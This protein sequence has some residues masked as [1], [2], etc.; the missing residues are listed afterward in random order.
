MPEKEEVFEI[1]YMLATEPIQF[2]DKEELLRYVK[3]WQVILYLKDWDITIRVVDN[4]DMPGFSSTKSVLGFCAKNVALK[5]ATL[6]LCSPQTYEHARGF[7]RWQPVYDMEQVLVHEMLHIVWDTDWI[8]DSDEIWM[9]RFI[10]TV[11][12]G[13]EQSAR[14]YVALERAYR[15]EIYGE[16]EQHGDEGKGKG[17]D[18]G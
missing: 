10:G 4:Q 2:G 5:S 6:F 15:L 14:S 12:G 13:I 3:R 16:V 9:D 7:S 18:E 17:K 8:D 1:D 11:E